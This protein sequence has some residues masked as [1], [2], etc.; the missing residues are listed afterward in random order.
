MNWNHIIHIVRKDIRALRFHL[1]LWIL[2]LIL[3]VAILSLWDVGMAG[4]ASAMTIIAHLLP[5]VV[6]I[7]GLVIVV[8]LIHH[9]PVAGTSAFWTTRPV[10]GTS[11]LVAKAIE[12]AAMV[13]LWFFADFLVLASN[14]VAGH[15][16]YLAFDFATNLMPVMLVIFAIAALAPNTPRFFLVLVLVVV[17]MGFVAMV[18]NTVTGWFVTPDGAAEKHRTQSERL[19]AQV[20]GATIVS[21]GALAVLGWQFVTRRTRV[22]LAAALIVAAGTSVAV[23]KWSHDF[24]R[25]HIDLDDLSDRF[26]RVRLDIDSS[27]FS[28]GGTVISTG[29]REGLE[30]R[31]VSA[32][33]SI[34]GVPD[35]VFAQ[36]RRGRTRVTTADGREFLLYADVGLGSVG[37]SKAG[38]SSALG[39]ARFAIGSSGQSWWTIVRAD[40]E[41]YE[42]FAHQPCEYESDMQLGLYSY[43]LLGELPLAV[44]AEGQF[45]G[46]QVEITAVVPRSDSHIGPTIGETQPATNTTLECEVHFN[47]KFP[48][49]KLKAVREGG[50]NQAQYSNVNY[51]L[52]NR[53]ANQAVLSNGGGSSSFGGIRSIFRRSNRHLDF[54]PVFAGHGVE[55]FPQIDEEWLAGATLAILKLNS[56]GEI[57]RTVTLEDAVFEPKP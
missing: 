5:G 44:G 25:P 53:K 28:A 9:D 22:S 33:T 45:D 7:Y 47:E 30:F 34:H 31:T 14:G 27:E 51:I 17:G 1:A 8:T 16:G 10:C 13:V 39:G 38:L 49:W 36:V 2:M 26:D 23:A 3:G 40:Q 52:V 57:S 21:L 32:L 19:S 46:L 54:Q 37:T 55:K 50:Q 29:S 24:I 35:G 41:D 48:S 12:A 20:V 43:D 42:Q 4:G 6:M 18:L 56:L 15:A 11:L